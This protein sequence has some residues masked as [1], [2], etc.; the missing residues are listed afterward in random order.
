MLGANQPASTQDNETAICP[1]DTKKTGQEG[2]PQREPLLLM[3]VKL[4]TFKFETSNLNRFCESLF[5]ITFLF[6]FAVFFGLCFLLLFVFCLWLSFGVFSCRVGCDLFSGVV[7][8]FD[9][10]F[11]MVWLW[12]SLCVLCG[13]LCGLFCV[14]FFCESHLCSLPP[15]PPL[16]LEI[17]FV[18]H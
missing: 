15:F 16:K 10:S 5:S 1:Q 18:N 2:S 6:L 3:G 8:V 9:V 12:C 4:R 17:T 13:V 11:C 7:V 14:V